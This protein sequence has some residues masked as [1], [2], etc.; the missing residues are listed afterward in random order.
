MS[1]STNQIFEL[2]MRHGINYIS[3]YD[4]EFKWNYDSRN[5][6][7]SFANKTKLYLQ[8]NKDNVDDKILKF[9]RVLEH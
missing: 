8:K 7:C 4:G 3:M 6:I 5:G 2:D 1:I 9:Q